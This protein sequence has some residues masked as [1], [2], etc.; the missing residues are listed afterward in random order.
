MFKAIKIINHEITRKILRRIKMF[1]KFRPLWAEINLD[2]LSHNVRGIK[3][4]L[5]K[6]T[7][8]IAV[9]KADG[10]GHGVVEVVNEC[11]ENGI[12]WF[13]VAILDEALELR[14]AGVDNPLLILGFT[15]E[16]RAEDIVKNNISQTC[17][18]YE[19]ALAMS[20]AAIACNKTA[21]LHIAIDTGMGRI[22]FLPTCES[23]DIIK[24]ISLLP[25]VEIEGLFTHF[26]VADEIDK[27]YTNMQV[28]LYNS[29]L[30]ML[31][32]RGIAIKYKH[33][34][35]SASILD[36]PDFNMDAVRPGIIQYGLYPSNEVIKTR[37]DLKPVMSVKANII[38]IKE[39]VEGTSISYGR[40]FVALRR[41][42]IATL[43]VGYADGFTMKLFEKAR[44]IINGEF[45]PVIGRICMDQCMIDI[46]D[47]GQVNV[48]D[49]VILLGS[50]GNLEISAEDI[51]DLIGTINYEVVCMFS[52]RIPRVYIKNG[53]I[54]KIKNYLLGEV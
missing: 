53:G 28:S 52:R 24:I 2:N 8:Y 51:A 7:E 14:R 29:F 45:A 42:R 31:E 5:K 17:F 19:L 23:A 1:S 34:G 6:N 20:E 43:P 18:S 36:L 49:E 40:K 48:G 22:G 54:V 35:N 21:K 27:D 44:V 25:N 9:V 41:S 3:A 13:A 37:I 15:Q 4:L 47:A 26:A 32:L 16:C 46:T 30:H 39:V 12:R 38:H 11:I 33:V 10:Y 50:D